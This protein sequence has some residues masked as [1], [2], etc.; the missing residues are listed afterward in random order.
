MD[1]SMDLRFPTSMS[2]FSSPVSPYSPFGPPFMPEAFSLLP[3]CWS[4][5]IS[6]FPVVPSSP[7][8]GNSLAGH[9]LS[10]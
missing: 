3:F 8:W 1:L 10:S 6:F 2:H 9:I 5:I 4:T 7:A